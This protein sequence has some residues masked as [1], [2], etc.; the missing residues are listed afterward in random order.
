MNR[1]AATLLL[2]LSSTFAFSGC[3]EGPLAGMARLNPF[4]HSDLE[5]E[6]QYGPTPAETIAKLRVFRESAAGLPPSR[7][8]A[9]AAA[10]ADLYGRTQ[11]L[12]VRR[13]IVLTLS[14]LTAPA[15]ESVLNA[16]IK[17]GDSQIRL[18]AC[19]A[20]SKRKSPAAIQAL[21]ETLASDTDI[22][23]RL[24]AADGLAA[25][26]DSPQAQRAVRALSVAVE[27]GDPALRHRGVLSLRTL[28]G[29]NYRE[30]SQWQALARGGDPG[31]ESGAE[32]VSWLPGFLR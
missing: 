8:Q 12:L 11:D 24:A 21:A 17:D 26:R 28:T 7:Q 5:I 20:W 14:A 4:A 16:A 9:E 18:A 1:R 23:V 25:F 19:R 3:A 27:D 13:E 2:T 15:A 29:R 31:P 32:S 6:K 22:D 10:L 30:M